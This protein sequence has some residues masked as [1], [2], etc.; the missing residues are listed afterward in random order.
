MEVNIMNKIT[1]GQPMRI[2]FGD[3]DNF[4]TMIPIEILEHRP[5][6]WSKVL[7]RW[8]FLNSDRTIDL[9]HQNDK[10]VDFESFNK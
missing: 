1:K 9:W 4:A 10:N 2:E 6:E 7:I 3:Y 8:Q 5:N